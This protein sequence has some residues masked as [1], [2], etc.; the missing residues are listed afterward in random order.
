MRS[1]IERD[2]GETLPA[3]YAA[4]VNARTEEAYSSELRIIPGVMSAL[5]GLQVPVCVASS[6]FPDK[7]RFGLEIV[8][9]YDRFAPNIISTSAVARGKPEPDVFIF[10]AGWMRVPPR[11]CVVVEDSVAGATAAH[12]AGMRVFGFEGGSHCRPGHG[13]RLLKAGAERVFSKMEQLPLLL[14]PQ[15]TPDQVP[16]TAL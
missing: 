1:E 3:D 12:R 14:L 2:W 11:R 7:L 6:S 9:L 8:G 16:T 5:D 15:L 10:A 4:R 13:E